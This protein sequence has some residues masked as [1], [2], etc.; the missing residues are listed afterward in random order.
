MNENYARKIKETIPSILK[1]CE[2]DCES[3]IDCKRFESGN[4]LTLSFWKSGNDWNNNGGLLCIGSSRTYLTDTNW[5]Q[6]KIWSLVLNLSDMVFP[7]ALCWVPCCS[8]YTSMIYTWQLNYLKPS[9]SQTIIISC[10]LQKPLDLSF[11][12]LMLIT[13]M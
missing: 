1:L 5:C 7:K 12:K 11:Q 13:A 10:I 2:I 6:S 4:V 3:E 8:L 9:I